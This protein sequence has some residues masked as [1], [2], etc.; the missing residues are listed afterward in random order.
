MKGFR[1]E[2]G[3]QGMQG[4]KIV[5]VSHQLEKEAIHSQH[6]GNASRGT[7]SSQVNELTDQLRDVQAKQSHTEQP[8]SGLECVLVSSPQGSPNENNKV[9]SLV[10]S[11]ASHNAHCNVGS[12]GEQVNELL[13]KLGCQD[14][15]VGGCVLG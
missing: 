15:P 13:T 8:D 6:Q 9:S 12:Q 11:C 3:Y 1:W 10:K 7:G 4:H 5:S 2:S 14:A